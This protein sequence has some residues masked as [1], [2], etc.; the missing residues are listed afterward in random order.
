MSQKIS[1]PIVRKVLLPIVVA[2]ESLRIG[3]GDP[4]FG[5]YYAE[6]WIMDKTFFPKCGAHLEQQVK[7][8]ATTSP[9]S[10]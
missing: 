3:Q 6:L 1:T 8:F 7:D 5:N 10:K 2:M 9:N 4:F